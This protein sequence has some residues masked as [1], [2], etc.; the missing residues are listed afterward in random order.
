[1]HVSLVS[2]DTSHCIFSTH[3]MYDIGSA[4]VCNAVA[5]TESAVPS[6]HV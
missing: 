3:N 4:V 2:V 5:S 1:L 6:W